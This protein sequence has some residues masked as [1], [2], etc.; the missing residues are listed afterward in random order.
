[1]DLTAVQVKDLVRLAKDI[2]LHEA[3]IKLDSK[4]P[5]SIV[6]GN[7]Q[8]AFL[9]ENLNPPH[10]HEFLS[11]GN[12]I[13][14]MVLASKD[15]TYGKF[16]PPGESEFQD[17]QAYRSWSGFGRH[18]HVDNITKALEAISQTSGV[19]KIDLIDRFEQGDYEIGGALSQVAALD[20]RKSQS[21]TVTT[22]AEVKQAVFRENNKLFCVKLSV[23]KGFKSLGFEIKGHIV[24]G[25]DFPV[26]LISSDL[27]KAVGMIYPYNRS[28]IFVTPDGRRIGV[29]AAEASWITEEAAKTK[30][31]QEVQAFRPVGPSGNTKVDITDIDS[32]IG[33]RLSGL[34]R[35]V[36]ALRWLGYPDHQ[37]V[38][39]LKVREYEAWFSMHQDIMRR[40]KDRLGQAMSN[41]GSFGYLQSQ[42]KALCAEMEVLQEVMRRKGNP[43]TLELGVL[44]QL[45][46]YLDES[47][48]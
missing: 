1:M 11:N 14:A 46:K 3:T 43:E 18:R 12:H 9:S 2:G 13:S 26:I 34:C 17:I 6:V 33:D 8:W 20:I 32:V 4:H 28:N 7:D 15:F 19:V 21:R 39:M 37:I 25:V 5:E 36:S 44:P 35:P 47:R 16:R 23:L 42:A 38:K 40:A 31:D 29:D 45:I 41:T 10:G 30:I 24:P 22:K 48:A 27:F